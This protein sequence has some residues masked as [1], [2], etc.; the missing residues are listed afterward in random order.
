[1]NKKVVKKRD[2]RR[3]ADFIPLVNSKVP[4]NT[5]KLVSIVHMF[6][7]R[8]YKPYLFFN[9]E[10]TSVKH[11][12]YSTWFS[13]AQSDINNTWKI[14]LEY[15]D[16]KQKLFSLESKQ[17]YVAIIGS[18][19]HVYMQYFNTFVQKLQAYM[20]KH[21]ISYPGNVKF[22]E[23]PSIIWSQSWSC[24]LEKRWYS[25]IV[26]RWNGVMVKWC[27]GRMAKWWNYDIHR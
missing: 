19:S 22:L 7:K 4:T 11:V 13:K 23:M 26:V 17:R 6:E 16:T 24:L 18:K 14:A 25:E 21:N 27:Y 5:R 12:E 8:E 9:C 20:R 1:M 10:H 3:T 15:W 2:T